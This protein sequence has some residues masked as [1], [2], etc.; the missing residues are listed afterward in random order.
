M[1]PRTSSSA[2]DLQPIAAI[3]H[4][5]HFSSLV[6]LRFFAAI[7]VVYAH[8][9]PSFF[10]P[11]PPETTIERGFAVVM[12][13]FHILSGFTLAYVY[14]ALENPTRIYRFWM[15]RIGRIWPL[16][17]G[18]LA[19]VIIFPWREQLVNGYWWRRLAYNI[20]F[21]HAWFPT[22]NSLGFFNG[23]S[24]SLSTE[25][26]LYLLFPLLILGLKRTWHW[27]LAGSFLL[28][29]ATVAYCNYCNTHT[30]YN[31]LARFDLDP[32]A[33]SYVH[34][35]VRVFEF[36]LGMTMALFWTRLHGIYRIGA[37]MGTV[38]EA[39][40]LALWLVTRSNAHAM[41][42]ALSTHF[43]F[44]QIWVEWLQRSFFGYIPTVLAISVFSMN[45]GKLSWLLS[46]P[47]FVFM[48]E[49]SFAIYLIHMPI[50]HGFIVMIQKGVGLHPLLAMVTAFWLSM[51]VLS[52]VVHVAWERPCRNF[53]R[54]VA[55]AG[56]R[57][58]KGEP[59]PALAAPL[60]AG[61]RE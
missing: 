26:A 6:S 57:K 4:Y 2:G 46:A 30:R 9:L 58:R 40:V 48:G 59:A 18:V 3:P 39:G 1:T 32:L 51:F 44:G 52:Y 31:L 53:F 5:P 60:Q 15:A 25:F 56:W 17:I 42:V 7:F 47:F 24:W 50:A 12:V 49:L 34:P 23:P 19:M 14:P 8:C 38:A 28:T 21:T 55:S 13:F 11:L 27:K 43:H 29:I 37:I 20:T 54:W 22:T 16:H 10:G 45:R 61:S 33:V 36:V 41:A 35:F